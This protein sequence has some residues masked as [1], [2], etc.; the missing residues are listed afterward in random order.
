MV[1]APLLPPETAELI[2]L[3]AENFPVQSAS[4]RLCVLRWRWSRPGSGDSL[5][6]AGSVR[7]LADRREP[8]SG[9]SQ[10][11]GSTAHRGAQRSRKAHGA[12]GATGQEGYKHGAVWGFTKLSRY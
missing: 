6:R 5:Q 4:Q 9:V 1:S 8:P 12:A 2:V 7:A 3:P 11:C 10:G